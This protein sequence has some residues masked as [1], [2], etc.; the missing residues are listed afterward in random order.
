[1]SDVKIKRTARNLKYEAYVGGL[2]N[3]NSLNDRNRDFV[4]HET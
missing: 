4:F 3:L 1:M 2:K